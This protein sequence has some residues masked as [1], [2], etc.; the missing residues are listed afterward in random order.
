MDRRVA[1]LSMRLVD[2]DNWVARFHAP[3]CVISVC[4]KTPDNA[5]S[6]ER[7]NLL[8]P[9]TQDNRSLTSIDVFPLSC[10]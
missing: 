6:T 10:V 7:R 8:M 9:Q 1:H 3:D 4:P 2:K 5:I